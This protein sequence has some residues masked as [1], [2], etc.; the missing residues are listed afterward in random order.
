M[1]Y[2]AFISTY[3]F[4]LS[5][6]KPIEIK[7]NKK[8]SK[9]FYLLLST[10]FIFFFFSSIN[11]LSLEK[12]I[13]FKWRYITAYEYLIFTIIIFYISHN[14]IKNT[15][16][17]LDYTIQAVYSCGLIY[18]L[19][20]LIYYEPFT[21]LF[22][23]YWSLFQIQSIIFLSY[24]L[25]I[26]KIKIDKKLI[27]AF[28]FWLSFSIISY[29]NIYLFFSHNP[30]SKLIRIPTMILLIALINNVKPVYN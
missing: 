29:G 22:T 8:L 11:G 5:Y 4:L 26:L 10:I 19:P 27:I 17:A 28:L 16:H 2:K 30:L 3:S 1:L 25:Y 9:T 12:I 24:K 23:K 21:N 18:E 13:L 6:Y 7:I 14:K 15:L 20:S